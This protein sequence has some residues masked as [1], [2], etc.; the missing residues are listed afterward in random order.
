MKDTTKQPEPM[1]S[2]LSESDQKDFVKS[3]IDDPL[4]LGQTW[5]LLDMK[6]YEKWKDFVNY[7]NSA[8]DSTLDTPGPI[9]NSELLTSSGVLKENLIESINFTVIPE[10]IWKMLLKCYG[11]VDGQEPLARCVIEV[12]TFSKS[13]RVEVYGLDLFLSHYK[14][15]TDGKL[16]SCSQGMTVGELTAKMRGMYNVPDAAEVKLVG[17]YTSSCYE[18]LPKVDEN[19]YNANLQPRQFVVILEKQGAIWPDPDRYKNTSASNVFSASKSATSSSS[20]STTSK[21]KKRHSIGSQ[22]VVGESATVNVGEVE[23][24]KEEVPTP[25]LQTYIYDDIFNM[26]ETGLFYKLMLDKTLHFK[27]AK[28]SGEKL[29]KEKLTVALCANMSGTEKEVPIVIGKSGEGRSLY[30]DSGY[31]STSYNGSLSSSNSY[32]G[33]EKSSSAGLCGLNNLGNTCFM[34]SALQCLSN[35]PDL[36][37][38]FLSNKWSK[39]LN[40]KNPLGMKGEI[41]ETYADLMKVMWSGKTTSC[42]PRHFKGAVGRF[43]PRFSGYHQQDSHELMAFLLDGLHEDLNRIRVKPYIETKDSNKRPDEEVSNEAWENYKKR[44][45]SIIIDLFHGQL[46]STLTCPECNQTS[47]TFDP[48]CYLSLP[49][50]GKD[51][52]PLTVHYVSCDPIKPPVK[53]KVKV[54]ADGCIEDLCKAVG[55]MFDLPADWLVAAELYKA[56]FHRIY[57]NSF[58]LRSIRDCDKT[59]VYKVDPSEDR[60]VVAVYFKELEKKN[61]ST[62]ISWPLVLSVPKDVTYARLY[63]IIRECYS[64]FIDTKEE[65]AYLNGLREKS[66][67]GSEKNSKQEPDAQEP[68]DVSVS[69]NT[70]LDDDIAGVHKASFSNSAKSYKSISESGEEALADFKMTPNDKSIREL[71]KLELVSQYGNTESS[72]PR[73]GPIAFS[74]KRY[75]LDF[76]L[77]AVKSIYS[78]ISADFEKKLLGTVVHTDDSFAVTEH[79]S[80]YEVEK[81]KEGVTLEDCLHLFTSKEQLGKHDAWYCPECKQHVLASKEFALWKL[82]KYLVIQLK[83]YKSSSSAYSY[84]SRDKINTFVSYPL[85]NLDMSQW[86]KSKQAGNCLYDLIAVSNHFG[87][88]GGGHYTAFAKNHRLKSWYNFD[89]SSVSSASESS[90]VSRSGYLLIYARQQKC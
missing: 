8:L 53:C 31:G 2:S 77:L 56:R 43:A 39:D 30:G 62:A 49:I 76:Y 69:S 19:L 54:P 17:S 36:K 61:T 42:A 22:I 60:T 21:W 24:W 27:G 81:E 79:E 16:V 37:D 48:T 70:D 12:G 46:K 50:P 44:N 41:A 64:P 80:L 90:I 7:D 85:D 45:D 87:G 55:K 40:E 74:S 5:Y 65:R 82:P 6:W 52:K 67:T 51:T 10:N 9:D 34:N 59:F 28:C 23:K 86:V 58:S 88:L 18:E 38:F 89:D 13:L 71:F 25:L 20:T 14:K 3:H 83:R 73:D 15:P 63:D 68:M 1:D 78:Y 4:D 26:N 84:G 72:L 32:K 47:T 57:Q 33:E 11:I 75:V 29:S 35:V 66:D